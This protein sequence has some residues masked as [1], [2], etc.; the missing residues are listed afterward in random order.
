MIFGA[1]SDAHAEIGVH[2]IRFGLV[3]FL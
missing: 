2:L 3:R 1:F